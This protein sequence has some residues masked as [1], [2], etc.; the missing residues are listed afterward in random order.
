M[1][2]HEITSKRAMNIANTKVWPK[3]DL[4]ITQGDKNDQ[5]ENVAYMSWYRENITV[6][7]YNVRI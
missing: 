4:V 1:H 3:E 5:V 6:E 2:R 7:T